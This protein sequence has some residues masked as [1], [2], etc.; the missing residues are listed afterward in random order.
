MATG[1]PVRFTDVDA[2]RRYLETLL[3]QDGPV[4]AHCRVAGQATIL[5]GRS[6]RP[7]VY[8]CNACRKPFSVT[9][10]T[11]YERSHIPLNKWLYANHLLCS[12]QSAISTRRLARML[13]VSYKTAWYMIH[14]IREAMSAEPAGESSS[15]A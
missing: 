15:M 7:G 3:W 9:V 1:K 14:R 8:W 13:G 4:C 11:I 6:T 2:A 10:G 5:K 12:S